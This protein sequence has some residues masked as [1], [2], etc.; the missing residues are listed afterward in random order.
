MKTISKRQ[1]KY[2][3]PALLI[4]HPLSALKLSHK[5]IKEAYK[6]YPICLMEYIENGEHNKSI[7]I[8]LNEGLIILTCSFNKD[9][10][11][12]FVSLHTIDLAIIKQL[13]SYLR[14]HYYYNYTK[15]CWIVSGIFI[16][17]RETKEENGNIYLTFF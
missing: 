5:D 11:C 9:E 1:S 15:S 12:N 14:K 8:W 4:N 7:E 17:V 10:I 16:R 3:H 6:N 2:I 13:I